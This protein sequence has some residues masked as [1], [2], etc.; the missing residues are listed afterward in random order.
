MVGTLAAKTTK[1]VV[2]K[3]N[4]LVSAAYRL[5]LSEQRLILAGI[6]KIDPRKPMPKTVTVLAM[7]YAAIYGLPLSRCY[8]QMKEAT[9]HL[10]ERDI[11]TFDGKGQERKRWVYK[12]RYVTG[13]ARVEICFTLDVVPYLSMLYQNVTSYDLN[14]VA[15]LESVYSFRLFELLMQF[16]STGWR[17]MSV[18]DMRAY[19][20]LSKAYRRFNNFRQRVIDPSVAELREKSRLQIQYEVVKKGRRVAALKFVFLDLDK[21]AVERPEQ[22]S[23]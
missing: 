15:R 2:S 20:G 1:L 6:S 19:L 22:A 14:R 5:T 10:Y 23:L 7:D 13:E 9:D 17:H 11:K 21:V 12:A 3:S 4:P 18:E 8:E 16:R